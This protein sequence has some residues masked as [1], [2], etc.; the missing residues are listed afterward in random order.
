MKNFSYSRAR[1]VDHA[2]EAARKPGVALIAGGTSLLDLAKSAVEAPD[3]VIDIT[4]LAGFD[5][6]SVDDAGA[7]IGALAKMATVAD[8]PDIKAQFPAIAQSLAL[9]ASAQLRNMASLGGN[10]MQRTRCSYFRD[11][12]NFSACNKRSPGSGCSAI[13]GITRNH[14]ILGTSE[15]CIA[16]YPGDLGVALTAFDAVVDLGSRKVGIDDF[17]LPYGA[18][19]HLETVLQPGEIISAIFIPASKAAANSL[20]LKVRDRQSYEFAAASAAVGLEFEAD[21]RTVKDIRVAIGGVASKPWR[22]RAVERALIGK[23]LDERIVER[24]SRLAVEGAVTQGDNHY[25]VHLA[26]R[27]IARA[28]LTL[29]GLA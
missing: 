14:A 7:T 29:G 27:T 6:I 23:T 10:L 17:F 18:A 2:R 12:A 13:G 11:P 9:S 15:Q 22:A 1:S 8:H 3:D 26:P 19:P 24:A 21:G 4:R 28:I 5:A 20:Y 16:S 25:K